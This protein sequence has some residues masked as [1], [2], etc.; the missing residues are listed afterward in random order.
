MKATVYYVG[1]FK[2]GYL[3]YLESGP[4]VNLDDAEDSAK[5]L[6]A[7][8]HLGL[9]RVVEHQIEVTKSDIYEE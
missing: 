9:Y 1:Y 7:Q 2:N 8:G 6:D 4:F 3:S 5:G